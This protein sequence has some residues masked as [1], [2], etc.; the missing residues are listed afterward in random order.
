[1]RLAPTFLCF[2]LIFSVSTASAAPRTPLDSYLAMR[3]TY[4]ARLCA[5]HEGAALDQA[6]R[7]DL[8]DLE[9][10]L[11]AVV[12]PWRGPGN[13]WRRRY[14]VD[15]LCEGSIDSGRLDGFAYELG[16]RSNYHSITATDLGVF[17]WWL[18]Q[19]HAPWARLDHGAVNPAAF[20]SEE[21]YGR[22]LANEAT[23]NLQGAVPVTV[24]GDVVAVVHLAAFAQDFVMD[25]GP[26]TLLAVVIRGTRVFIASETMRT[27]LAPIATCRAQMQRILRSS[28]GHPD[29]DP[30]NG[31]EARADRAYRHCF[32]Q[33]WRQLPGAAAV[34]QQAQ[35]FVNLLH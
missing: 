27:N 30:D 29:L 4:A 33:H 3:G 28:R 34:Q 16:D 21:F 1:M 8:A 12:P 22:A 23:A 11:V 13:G 18:G 5:M 15:D 7:R 17:N 25:R 31:T 24:P 6:S 32:A 26:D 35:R 9:R 20:A 14:T 2:C 10:L 19:Q